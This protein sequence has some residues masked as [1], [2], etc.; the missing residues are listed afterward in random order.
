M[1]V[2][3]KSITI[4]SIISFVL[5]VALM[6]CVFSC[7]VAKKSW[8]EENF[9]EKS[10]IKEIKESLT[11]SNELIK[12]DVRQTIL[13][14]FNSKLD[15]STTKLNETLNENT[16]TKIDIE[17]EF[18]KIKEAMVGNTKITSNGAKISV[19]TTTSKYL[20]KDFESYKK[21][22]K[23]TIEMLLN[24]NVLLEKNIEI[25][26]KENNTLKSE[27]KQIKETQSR[28]VTKKQLGLGFVLLIVIGLIL[29]IINKKFRFL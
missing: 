2:T 20:Q 25:V 21:D 13:N 5:Y 3:I 10:E 11:Y 28:Y 7:R 14:E 22:T 4:T 23:E 19:E 9:T 8:V 17:A 16:I 15:E 18:G 29:Y 12:E 27:L 1:K 24:E 26:A 6:L